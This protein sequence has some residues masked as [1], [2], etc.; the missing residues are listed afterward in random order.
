MESKVRVF[1]L[2]VMWGVI[3]VIYAQA[4]DFGA[5]LYFDDRLYFVGRALVDDWWGA[6]WSDRL[7]TPDVGY[8]NPGPTAIYAA[9]RSLPADLILPAVHAVCVAMFALAAAGFWAVAHALTRSRW[10]AWGVA[11]V[12][13]AHPLMVESAAWLTNLKTVMYGVGYT[14]TVWAWWRHLESEGERRWLAGVALGAAFALASRPSGV[15]LPAIMVVVAWYRGGWSEVRSRRVLGPIV[16]GGLLALAYVPVAMSNHDALIQ[17]GGEFTQTS[18]S[19]VGERLERMGYAAW[20]QA[21]HMVWPATLDPIYDASASRTTWKVGLGWALLVAWGAGA[22]WGVLVKRTPW[23]L[24]LGLALLAYAPASNVTFLPRFTA[25]TYAFTPSFWLIF[26]A[27]TWA[28]SRAEGWSE[29]AREKAKLYVAVG[30]SVLVVTLAGMSYLQAMRWRG[31]L[32]LWGDMV[33]R[34]TECIQPYYMYGGNLV[35]AGAYERAV[36]VYEARWQELF[37]LGFLPREFPHALEE[38]G[39]VQ[40]AFSASRAIW[41]SPRN[42]RPDAACEVVYFG[43]KVGVHQEDAFTECLETPSLSV[44]RLDAIT[45]LV[46]PE[47]AQALRLAHARR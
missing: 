28:A 5:L 36:A 9:V 24:G 43:A 35:R 13:C 32:S 23:G 22:A 44:G 29:G 15:T 11:M 45:P 37:E 14:A 47:Q 7:L 12:W 26:A 17:S 2:A 19:S 41:A 38:V 34:Q 25:D 42:T 1:Q 31:G 21:S 40:D 4:W 20:I 3:A 39:R 18:F 30:G 16:V 6:P 10:L 27:G 46:T 8:P 33:A